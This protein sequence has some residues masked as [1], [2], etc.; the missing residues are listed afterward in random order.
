MAKYNGILTI[1]SNQSSLD[2][3]LLLMAGIPDT[4]QAMFAATQFLVKARNLHSGQPI[5]ATGQKGS[6]GT[7]SIIVMSDAQ[8]AGQAF[9][10]ANLNVMGMTAASRSK[11]EKPGKARSTTAKGRT[12]KPKARAKHGSM[13]GR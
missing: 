5:V 13:G 10:A 8:A 11:A 7:V 3:S 12:S 4:A 9:D 6:I 2:S 1:I